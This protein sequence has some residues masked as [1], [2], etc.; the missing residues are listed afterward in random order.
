MQP[1]KS[2]PE[3]MPAEV[4]FEVINGE[5]SRPVAIDADHLIYANASRKASGFDPA[6]SKAPVDPID[7]VRKVPKT[8]TVVS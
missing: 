8:M 4:T 5:S 6:G 2:V 7:S 1:C 3:S